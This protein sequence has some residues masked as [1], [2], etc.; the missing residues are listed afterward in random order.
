MSD[1]LGLACTH[2]E[3]ATVCSACWADDPGPPPGAAYLAR[4]ALEAEGWTAPDRTD[5]PP[6]RRL[7]ALEDEHRVAHL[8]TLHAETMAELLDGLAREVLH[9]YRYALE[10]GADLEDA[11]TRRAER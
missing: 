2:G 5:W 3:D 1:L 7:R 10:L 4:A 11:I 9:A 6:D 8:E